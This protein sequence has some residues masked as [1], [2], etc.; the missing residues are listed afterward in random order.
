MMRPSLVTF[1]LL[2]ATVSTRGKIIINTWAGPFTAAT[3][4]GYSIMNDL[5]GSCL[6]AVEGG[7]TTCEVNQC[8]TSVGYG[9]HPDSAGGVT[10]DA[11]IMDGQSFNVGS[12]AFL[13]GYR[14]AA[15]IARLVMEHTS[16]TLLVGEGAEAFAHMMGAEAQHTVTNQS[17]QVYEDW[18]SNSCQ[19][20]FYANLPGCDEACPPYTSEPPAMSAINSGPTQRPEL[21]V[22]AKV[23]ASP[24]N[25]DTIGMV[26]VDAAGHMACG[27]T[28]NGANHKVR[29]RVG[30]S[31]IAGSGCYVDGAVGGCAGTGDGDVMMRFSPSFAAVMFMQQGV[32]PSEAAQKALQPIIQHF[33]SFS[34]GLVCLS[35]SQEYGA[36]TYNMGFQMSVMGD[37]MDEVEV[38]NVEDMKTGSVMGAV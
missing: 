15:S 31:P 24:D 17:L 20:N 29:G 27:T 30:D 4:K 8:D 34:G 11:L 25:H 26:A 32:A 7:C 14:N 38:I 35:A 5:Q 37:G 16:H 10:L 18:V 21:H 12:V 13:S 6:D 28:T 3:E 9:N 22:E 23:W 19:P 33:P 2:S 1:L 36:A